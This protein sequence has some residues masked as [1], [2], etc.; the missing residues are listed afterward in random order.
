MRGNDRPGYA[1]GVLDLIDH[2]CARSTD[3]TRVLKS[4]IDSFCCLFKNTFELGRFP[5][6]GGFVDLVD[7]ILGL[8][9]FEG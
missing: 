3:L 6:S 5:G 7:A 2:P 8:R 4:S 9:F 1:C